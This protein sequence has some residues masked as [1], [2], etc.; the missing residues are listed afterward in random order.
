MF[1]KV[2]FCDLCARIELFNKVSF[3]SLNV[4]KQLSKYEKFGKV[5]LELL[6]LKHERCENKI[7]WVRKPSC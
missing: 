5:N 7:K 1:G 4:W 3:K 2:N 6:Y